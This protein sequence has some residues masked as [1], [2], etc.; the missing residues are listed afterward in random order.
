[1]WRLIAY[2]VSA[3]EWAWRWLHGYCR[4][5]CESLE[6]VQKG[7]LTADEVANGIPCRCRDC[8]RQVR[9]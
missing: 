7:V 3:A 5:R 6:R 9:V 8:G 4:P 2:P 1:M